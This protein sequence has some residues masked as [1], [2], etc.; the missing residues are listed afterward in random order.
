MFNLGEKMQVLVISALVALL[1][2][3]GG[4]VVGNFFNQDAMSNNVAVTVKAKEDLKDAV[5]KNNQAQ[6]EII[7]LKAE[8]EERKK[9]EQEV[10]VVEEENNKLTDIATENIKTI[11]NTKIVYVEK[12]DD[13]SK[14]KI[15]IDEIW[16]VYNKRRNNENNIVTNK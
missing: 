11:D 2:L 14:S 1:L 16:N 10:K 9:V 13:I 4:V 5:E 7:K 3:A 6:E 8:I 15:I 12:K